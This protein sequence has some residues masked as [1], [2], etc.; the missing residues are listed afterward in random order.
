[1]GTRS[2]GKGSVQTIIPIDRTTAIKLTTALYYTPSGRSIQAKGIEPDIVVNELKVNK[3]TDEKPLDEIDEKDL[4]GHLN[5][6]NAKP[7]QSKSKE[8]NASQS[9]MNPTEE[10]AVTPTNPLVYEDFQLFEALN[11]LKGIHVEKQ[12]PDISTSTPTAKTKS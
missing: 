3:D 1:M 6:G 9:I 8:D 4:S 11:A 2:F 7:D 12:S 10:E 5:N